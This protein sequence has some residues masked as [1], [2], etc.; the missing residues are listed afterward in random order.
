MS[1]VVAFGCSLTYGMALSDCHKSSTEA[2]PVPSKQAW[3]QLIADQLGY[4]CVNNSYPGSSNKRIWHAVATFNFKP[5]DIVFIQ[6]THLGRWAVLKDKNSIV[7]IGLWY[8]NAN[9]ETKPYFDNLYA[10]YDDEIQTAL[11]IN[12]A[13]CILKS[14]GILCYH[15]LTERRDKKLLTLAGH[16]VNHIPLYLDTE[17]RQRFPRALD[18]THPGAECHM[19]YAR[20][21]LNYLNIPTNIP[22]QKPM[23]FFERKIKRFRGEII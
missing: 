8:G 15:L 1:R 23:G 2:G 13:D 21:I 18:K 9:P 5:G 14:K 22:K 17:H 6:W 4:A 11:F 12:N 10:Q 16:T 19:E 20:D 7:D 3:P